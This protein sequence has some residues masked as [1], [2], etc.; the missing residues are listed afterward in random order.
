MCPPSGM[1]AGIEQH[2]SLQHPCTG[3]EHEAE[4]HGAG[5]VGCEHRALL[6]PSSLPGQSTSTGQGK[7]GQKFVAGSKQSIFAET[8]SGSCGTILAETE[9][10]TFKSKQNGWNLA[11]VWETEDSILYWEV[12]GSLSKTTSPACNNTAEAQSGRHTVLRGEMT[13]PS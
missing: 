11:K 2:C 5:A 12:S 13:I 3:T 10:G 9:I 4:L 8:F 7:V 1:Q 6:L